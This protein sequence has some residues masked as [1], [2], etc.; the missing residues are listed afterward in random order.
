MEFVLIVTARQDITSQ[1][2]PRIV[3]D[4]RIRF[5]SLFTSEFE[6]L[7]S[8]SLTPLL[9]NYRASS[10]FSIQPLRIEPLPPPPPS[11]PPGQL[12][13]LR[14]RM[15][16]EFLNP[17]SRSIHARRIGDRCQSSCQRSWP[18]L[19]AR[20]IPTCGSWQVAS[21][22]PHA[23]NTSRSSTRFFNAALA[24]C[25]NDHYTLN[26]VQIYC[27][28]QI[29]RGWNNSSPATNRPRGKR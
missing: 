15:T 22:I 28:Y 20:T 13:V 5:G 7:H 3:Y 8:S 24:P 14:L 1:V 29:V 17:Y 4:L 10:H 23:E 21:G 26:T 27:E 11:P 16:L 2:G 6:V 9:S 25:L 12:F 18:G 19:A